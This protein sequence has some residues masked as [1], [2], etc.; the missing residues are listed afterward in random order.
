MGCAVYHT[1]LFIAY[2]VSLYVDMLNFMILYFKDAVQAHSHF[3]YNVL[4]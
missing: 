1:S 3:T 4:L 2:V